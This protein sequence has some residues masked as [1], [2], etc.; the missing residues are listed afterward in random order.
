MVGLQSHL[1]ETVHS[2]AAAAA[3]GREAVEVEIDVAGERMIASES[4]M[5]SEK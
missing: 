2:Y 4:S 5:D 3:A 1:A